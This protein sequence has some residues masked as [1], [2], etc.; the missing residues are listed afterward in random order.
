MFK[1]I[2]ESFSSEK[3]LIDTNCNEEVL[4][5]PGIK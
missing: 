5:F 3:L 4:L 2:M 1:L